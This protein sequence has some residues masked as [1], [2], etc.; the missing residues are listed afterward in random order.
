MSKDRALFTSVC[1]V[2]SREWTRTLM[3]SEKELETIRK[4]D[5]SLM[6]FMGRARCDDCRTRQNEEFSTRY[7]GKWNIPKAETCGDNRFEII[8]AAKNDILEST[9]IGMCEDEMKV[10]DSFLFRC[11]QMGWLGKYEKEKDYV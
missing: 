7:L 9:N 4:G 8:E 2:C 11:W 5:G 6:H 1:P 3:I 10:L